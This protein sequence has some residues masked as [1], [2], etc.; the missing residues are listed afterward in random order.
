[1]VFDHDRSGVQVPAGTVEPGEDIRLAAI[2]E[3]EEETEVTVSDVVHLASFPEFPDP[4]ERVCVEAVPLL[5][6]PVDGASVLI[7]DLFRTVVRLH[8]ERVDWSNV[9][10]EEWD[11]DVDPPRMAGSVKGW[12]R[13]TALA[14][15]QM[16]HLYTC[17]A[18]PGVRESWELIAEGI[19]LFRCHWAPLDDAGLLAVHQAWVDMVRPSLGAR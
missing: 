3:L 16:R 17:D 4:D 12:V 9:G 18:P 13:T 15:S 10:V 1:M 19:Y 5:A 8:E 2:R 6:E 11:L 7:L 14:T